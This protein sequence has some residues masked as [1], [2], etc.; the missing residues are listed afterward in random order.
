MTTQIEV[1][2]HSG[3]DIRVARENNQLY[4]YKSTQD[5]KYFKRLVLQ[6]E[7]QQKASLPKMQF[8]RVPEIHSILETEHEVVVKMD[9]VYSRNFVEFFEKAGFEQV[10]Y[11][12]EALIMF[13]EKEIEDS[14]TFEIPSSII[15]EKFDDVKRKSLSN[16][17]IVENGYKD[18]VAA[19]IREADIIFKTLPEN[20]SMPVGVCHGD[21]TFS[22]I[23]FNGNNYYL[24]DFLD[25]FIESPLLDIVKIRQ[26]TAWQW[27]RLMYSGSCDVIRL[28][29]AFRKIDEKIHSHF[30]GKYN[31]YRS[32][33]RPMQLMNFL[34]ILQY[35]HEP[36]VT[37]FLI[38]AL[39][40]QLNEL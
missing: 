33:Y 24:I 2:G 28:K 16:R 8:I 32:F 39:N 30:N 37:E 4:I 3:C 38:N 6:A 27:S 26:D 20:L 15:T 7:K 35:A 29:I 19:I 36:E 12:I 21:L 11:L 17:F 1:Q 5:P 25:S 18:A 9:Y 31:W 14:T 40:S 10:N 23:L 13:L 34:R 22:N